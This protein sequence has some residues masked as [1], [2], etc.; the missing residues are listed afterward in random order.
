[1]IPLGFKSKG[2]E[3][4]VH[5]Y[6]A[7]ATDYVDITIPSLQGASHERSKS[8]S[9]GLLFWWVGPD[10]NNYPEIGVQ[11]FD[12]DTYGKIVETL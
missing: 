4:P 3:K 11:P 2:Y 10:D 5:R 7:I 6:T 1:L 8:L 9:V 12:G